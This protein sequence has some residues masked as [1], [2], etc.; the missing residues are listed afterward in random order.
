MYGMGLHRQLL[1]NQY[2]CESQ[3]GFFS[4][5]LKAAQVLFGITLYVSQ[6]SLCQIKMFFSTSKLPPL[7]FF[8]DRLSFAHLIEENLNYL[9]SFSTVIQEAKHD[10]NSSMTVS[11]W[12][13]FGTDCE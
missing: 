5:C 1:E 8:P 3:P 2:E 6:E 10:Q 9:D 13:T 4:L 12:G 11:L 7:L